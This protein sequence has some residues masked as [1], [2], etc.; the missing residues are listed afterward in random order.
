MHHLRA[1]LRIKKI[2]FWSESVLGRV[3]KLYNTGHVLFT[4]PTRARPLFHSLL[5]ASTSLPVLQLF[6]QSHNCQSLGIYHLAG[7][8]FHFAR[9]CDFAKKQNV[10]TGVGSCIF[11]STEATALPIQIRRYFVRL[12]ASNVAHMVLDSAHLLSCA[13]VSCALPRFHVWQHRNL[14][15]K[16]EFADNLFSSPV[17]LHV[18]H[19]RRGSPAPGLRFAFSVYVLFPFIWF[20]VCTALACYTLSH[21]I[22]LTVEQTSRSRRGVPILLCID[23]RFLHT[24]KS[25]L[26]KNST[27]HT[28]HEP[29]FKL[30]A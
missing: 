5:R 23:F 11:C 22:A 1:V 26:A 3:F 24:S 15:A 8:P 4:A 29:S 27:Q 14:R 2:M 20:R 17:P 19:L 30:S 12:R 6:Q 10:A 7:P 16:I 21:N 25:Q 13:S 9:R 18:F 28:C